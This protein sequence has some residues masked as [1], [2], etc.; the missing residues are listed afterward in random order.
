M[1][2]RI[3]NRNQDELLAENRRLI[4]ELQTALAKF[5]AVR[6]GPGHPAEL[7]PPARRAVPAGRRGR[8]QRRQERL[9]QRPAR[10]QGPG[11]GGHPHH[12]PRPPDPARPRG[13]AARP[14]SPPSTASPPRSS[15]CSDIN[16]VDTPGTNAI[17]REHEA[18]TREFVPRSDMVLFV[19]SADR[20]FTESERAFLQGIRE[21]GKKIVVVLNK[22]DILEYAR[23]RR[24]HPRLH[25]GERQGAPRLHPRDLPRRRPP[26]PARQGQPATA[27]CSPAAASRRW[28]RY[29]V[30]HARREGAHPPQAD[31]PAG[32]RL[33]PRGQV[34]GG[35]RR[36]AGA[37]Q[38]RLRHHG[39]HRAPAR[40][41]Q[42][43]HA[44]RVP[45]PPVGRRQ[46]PPRVR[47]PRRR[48]L[49]RDHAPR[50]LHRPDQQ[51]QDEG[52]L[53]APGGR[54]HAAAHRAARSTR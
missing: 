12:H 50:P 43:G 4:A 40:P 20:P 21:W 39:G 36:P 1:L 6:R 42:G 25:R 48:L 46:H 8:V 47:E 41:L 9:H 54:R 34:P 16:I 10:R 33:P 51:V 30:A 35:H 14:W 37:A 38:G 7:G 28:R 17:H 32:R 15:C 44:A 5:D 18:I 19:T 23:G 11:G 53:R 27:S 24:E 22:I 13:H 26:R 31:E 45:L 29:I 52:G 2:R 3:L 49:R